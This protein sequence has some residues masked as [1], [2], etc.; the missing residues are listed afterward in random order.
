[1]TT[2]TRKKGPLSSLHTMKFSRLVNSSH[3]GSYYHPF[4]LVKPKSIK[5]FLYTDRITCLLLSHNLVRW[6]CRLILQTSTR[7]QYTLSF[8]FPVYLLIGLTIAVT[9]RAVFQYITGEH[10]LAPAEHSLAPTEHHVS[11]F[12]YISA[13]L[14]T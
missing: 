12:S 11:P 7:I 6:Q 4:M 10:P 1:M 9:P 8:Y 13:T 3:T 5:L 14:P 2:G